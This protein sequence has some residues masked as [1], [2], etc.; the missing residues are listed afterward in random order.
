M[1]PSTK[2][3]W[4]PGERRSQAGGM[5]A[6]SLRWFLTG[7]SAGFGRTIAEAALAHGDAVVATARTPAA[8]DD[9]VAAAPDRMLALPLD[10][11]DPDQVRSATATAVATGGGGVL[12]HN[13]RHGLL[14]AVDG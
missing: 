5:N 1:D 8:L 10:V 2:M 7:A 4:T 9:L 6:G 3:S 14:G 13:G 12:V 11:T